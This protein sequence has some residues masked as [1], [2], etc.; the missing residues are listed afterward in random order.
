MKFSLFTSAF[1]YIENYSNKVEIRLQEG[2]QL[3]IKNTFMFKIAGA[4][5]SISRNFLRPALHR[6][7]R[8]LFVKY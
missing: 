6:F 4:R 1:N 2:A 7:F 3:S 8:Y 5:E